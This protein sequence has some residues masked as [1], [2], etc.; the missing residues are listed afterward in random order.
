MTVRAV[1]LIPYAIPLRAA[2][3]TGAGLI[4]ERRGVLVLLHGPGGLVGVGDAAPHPA[5]LPAAI[6]T[7]TRALREAARGLRGADVSRIDELVAATATLPAAAAT[8]IDMAL[9]DLA[10]RAQDRSL[11]ELLGGQRRRVIRASALLDGDAVEAARAA[12]RR[13]FT[14]AK[15]KL[16]AAPTAALA[17]I[18]AVQRAAPEL[19]L[20]L[21]PNGVWDMER[22]RRV[23]RGLDP[24]GIEWLEQPLPPADLPGLARL[25]R[26]GGVPVAADEAVT[27]PEAVRALVALGAADAIVVKLAQVGGLARARATASAAAQAGLPVAVTT[28]I[29]TGVATAA[30]LHVAAAVPG[31]LRPCGLATGV[32]LAGDLVRDR[33]GDLPDVPVPCGPGLGIRLASEAIQRWRVEEER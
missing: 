29:D 28:A 20:R 17:R 11:S 9:H 12:G 33:L 22:A 30:A 6:R 24:L 8:G 23:A 18:A 3:A 32:L 1:E 26:E 10:A 15:L 13:G 2:L 4:T 31:T 21:D 7:T 19:V 14:H 5:G 25:R 16:G 27:G